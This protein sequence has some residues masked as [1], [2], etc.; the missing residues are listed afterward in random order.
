MFERVADSLFGISDV[1]GVYFIFIVGVFLTLVGIVCLLMII[2]C[3]F[4]IVGYVLR[5]PS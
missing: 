3:L 1:L 2:A 5:M 4:S